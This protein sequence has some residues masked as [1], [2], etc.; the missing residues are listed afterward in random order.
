VGESL[1]AEVTSPSVAVSLASTEPSMAEAQ[2]DAPIPTTKPKV[3]PTTKQM[4]SAANESPKAVAVGAGGRLPDTAP[5]SNVE[6]ELAWN[7]TH[8]DR[9]LQAQLLKVC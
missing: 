8:Q 4:G 5:V 7:Q 3:G 2:V 1:V 6:F 9:Q